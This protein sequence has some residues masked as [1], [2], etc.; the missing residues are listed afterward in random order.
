MSKNLYTGYTVEVK[1]LD[2]LM[3]WL[4]YADPKLQK[5]MK[6]G[7]KDAA[8]PVLEKARANARAIQDDG[9]YA[10]SLSIAQRAG[11]IQ[12][13]LKSSD[14][15]AGVKEFAKP[16]AVV[17][18]NRAHSE[19]TQRMIANRARVG[20]PRRAN[21]PRVMVSAVEDSADEVKRRIDERLAEVLR[22]VEHG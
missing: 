20:V 10:G 12:Y 22:E 14:E 16:G 13:V 8:N 2:S 4:K 3:R 5:A 21:P 17:V 18:T 15:Q 7:L 6:K 19:R 11:G 9:T 1:G